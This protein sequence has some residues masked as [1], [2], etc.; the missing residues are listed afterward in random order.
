MNVFIER[1]GHLP[2]HV[3]LREQVKFLILNGELPPG[4]RLPAARHLAGFLRVNRNT[5]LRAYQDLV[6][7]GLIECRPGRGCVV[8]ER[9][10]A[11]APALP[12]PVL[13][14]VDGALEQAGAL[15]VDPATFATLVYARSR[16]RHA[17]PVRRRLAF[18]ECDPAIA[19]PLARIIQE[20]LGVE[21]IP[22]VLEELE[23]STPEAE[24]ALR[25]VRV[26]ATTFFHI[27]EVRRLLAKA[28][29][30]VVALGVKPH[31][32]NLI[33]IAAL[34]KGTPVAL[35]C[36][37]E[38]CALELQQSLE[39]AGIKGLQPVLGGVDDP[40]R[41]AAIL[42]GR[43]VVI[44]S[45]FVADQVRPLLQ[46]GQDLIT[47]DYTTLD[48]GAINLLRSLVMEDLQAGAT[49]TEV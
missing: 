7:E 33:Q 10:A 14:V 35:V 26:V 24:A 32:Q 5:V 40:H 34:P 45:D 2:I 49:N 48:E 23:Q 19:T 46:P 25:E 8:V 12:A 44:A 39:G 13:A 3:Q 47:L 11:A 16:Q 31:L 29:K 41:L 4:A 42:P 18:V 43:P 21:V 22:L 27:Q 28:D 38:C 6:Q 1:D 9:P 15:G 36:V 30:E 37:S 20:K 17:L